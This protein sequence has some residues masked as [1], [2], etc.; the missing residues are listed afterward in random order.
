MKLPDVY[1]NKIEKIIN[2]NDRYYHKEKEEIKKDISSIRNYF[3]D[4]GYANKLNVIIT[5]KE[6]KSN[7]RL[8]LCRRD[9]VININNKKIYFDEILDYE[10][11]K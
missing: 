4:N 10:I 7:E 5:T 3:D 11:K 6:G 8:I 9:Y 2:N 1:A